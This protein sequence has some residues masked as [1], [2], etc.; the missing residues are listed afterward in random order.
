MSFVDFQITVYRGSRTVEIVPGQNYL[1]TENQDVGL[2]TRTHLGRLEGF[3]HHEG[4]R[5]L[6]VDIHGRQDDFNRAHRVTL[7]H[8]QLIEPWVEEH[9]SLIAPCAYVCFYRLQI[10]VAYLSLSW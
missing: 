6:H 10:I 5:S 3:G 2:P 4:Y 1:S 7:Q 9:K 8:L